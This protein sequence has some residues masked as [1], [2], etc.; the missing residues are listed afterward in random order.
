MDFLASAEHTASPPPALILTWI[1]RPPLVPYFY[2]L[3]ASNRLFF[4]RIDQI[5]ALKTL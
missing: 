5:E 4:S 2:Q 3:G 1:A